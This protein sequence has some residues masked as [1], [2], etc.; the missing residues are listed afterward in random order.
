MCTSLS[1]R[2]NRVHMPCMAWYTVMALFGLGARWRGQLNKGQVQLHRGS[3]VIPPAYDLAFASVQTATSTVLYAFCHHAHHPVGNRPYNTP[4]RQS[5]RTTDK[6]QPPVSLQ[7]QRACVQLPHPVVVRYC[8]HLPCL[9]PNC[10][11]AKPASSHIHMQP[12]ESYNNSY[13][14]AILLF[15]SLCHSRC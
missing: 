5:T 10:Q 15:G 14:H 8:A 4:N 1:G 2:A 3:R 12:W 6:W 7:T 9:D 13:A 11:P